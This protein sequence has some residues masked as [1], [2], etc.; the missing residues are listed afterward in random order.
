M[1]SQFVSVFVYCEVTRLLATEMC[2]FDCRGSQ[3]TMSSYSAL[4]YEYWDESLNETF[5]NTISIWDR[6]PL[7]WLGIYANLF[8]KKL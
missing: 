3:F 6:G 1:P 4:F 8:K 2:C 7:I 5:L